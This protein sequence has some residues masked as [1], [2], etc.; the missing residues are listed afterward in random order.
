MHLLA[1][2][3]SSRPRFPFRFAPSAPFV[4]K[5]ACS[6]LH[7]VLI[8]QIHLLCGASFQCLPLVV[9]VATLV[10]LGGS[11]RCPF[12]Y[13]IHWTTLFQCPSRVSEAQVLPH[14]VHCKTCQRHMP[15]HSER[16]PRTWCTAR[17]VRGIRLLTW[18]VFPGVLFPIELVHCS[19]VRRTVS[20][21]PFS[22]IWV[23][24]KTC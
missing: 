14:M 9:G 17:F 19:D 24:C 22:P 20:E 10:H 11:P 18:R 1:W 6:V 4:N 3:V 23:P 15:P 5:F 12:P 7:V 13:R 16:F 2:R 21:A 8:Y